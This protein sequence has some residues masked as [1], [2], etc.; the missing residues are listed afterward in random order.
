MKPGNIGICGFSAGGHLAISCSL[1]SE[2]KQPAGQAS[3]RLNFA[4]LFYPGIPEDIG[5]IMAA[6]TDSE[7]D[8][9]HVCP[10]FI[11]NAPVD[12]LTPV[13]KC[14]DF[15]T[16]LLEAKVKAE[17]HIYSKGSHGFDLGTGRGKSLAIWPESFVT[18]LIDSSI[19]PQ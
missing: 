3:S 5:E 10:V 4:G 17:L 9:S 13:D 14:L 2:P 6:H 1:G 8:T 19:I 7:D 11:I 15:Y 16:M 12:R 18:W